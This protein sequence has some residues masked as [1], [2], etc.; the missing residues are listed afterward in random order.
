MAIELS[1]KKEL[2]TI[3]LYTKMRQLKK[4]KKRKISKLRSLRDLEDN[5]DQLR[6]I[7][8]HK[9]NLISTHKYQLTRIKIYLR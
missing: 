4:G 7:N 6:K 5:R 9:H 2:E 1:R 3:M 8:N